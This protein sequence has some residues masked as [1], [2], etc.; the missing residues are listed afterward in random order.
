MTVKRGDDISYTNK[1]NQ[2]AFEMCVVPEKNDENQV[3]TDKMSD[4]EE[5]KQRNIS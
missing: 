4:E 3:W 2:N 1:Q 5:L